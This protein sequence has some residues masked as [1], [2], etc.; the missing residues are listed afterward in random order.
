MLT[1]YWQAS[2]WMIGATALT[3]CSKESVKLSDAA[4]VAQDAPSD[5]TPVSAP[6]DVTAPD[7]ATGVA[8]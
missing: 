4:A 7:D 8:P 5:V 1:R 2:W 6:A 3:G